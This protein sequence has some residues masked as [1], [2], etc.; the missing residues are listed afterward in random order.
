MRPRLF[1]SRSKPGSPCHGHKR[2][3]ADGRPWA[4][5]CMDSRTPVRGKPSEHVPH[6]VR[7]AVEIICAIQQQGELEPLWQIRI[8]DRKHQ[9]VAI[10]QLALPDN[11][12][13]EVICSHT[14][15]NHDS[16]RVD[17]DDRGLSRNATVLATSSVCTAASA[18]WLF[19]R[20]DSCRHT[21]D[22]GRG[23]GLQQTRAGGVE[24]YFRKLRERLA[25]KHSE[26]S[27]AAL[28]GAIYP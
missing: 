28:T 25:R 8:T 16:L 2:V 21:R 26:E 14:G 12:V 23:R 7:I 10:H 17:A 1:G 5:R 13:V 4:V 9:P 19:Q 18:M 11:G 22:S 27:S 15:I 3:Q 24:T 20:T 6:N